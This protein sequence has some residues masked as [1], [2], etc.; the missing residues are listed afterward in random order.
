MQEMEPTKV[1]VVQRHTVRAGPRQPGCDGCVVMAEHPHGRGHIQS[2]RQRREH[3]RYPLGWGFEVVEWRVTAS[4][5]GGSTHLAAEG[6]DSLDFPRRSIAD[7]GMELRVG[8][9]VVGAGGFGAG[10]AGSVDTF[11]APR[12]LLTADHGLSGGRATAV[13]VGAAC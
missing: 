13:A 2:F 7:Q 5:E 4:T 11:G 3:F 12:R 6:L 8:D 10:V 9:T 1:A